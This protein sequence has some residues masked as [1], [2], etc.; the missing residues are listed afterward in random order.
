MPMGGQ[1]I[2]QPHLYWSCDNDNSIRTQIG[3]NMI[4]D[5]KVLAHRINAP[6]GKSPKLFCLWTW[7]CPWQHCWQRTIIVANNSII[8]KA[9]KKDNCAARKRS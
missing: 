7:L 8:I 5:D 3:Q 6:T 1:E 9:K 4:N 2:K